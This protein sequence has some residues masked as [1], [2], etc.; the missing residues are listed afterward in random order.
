MAQNDTQPVMA[1]LDRFTGPK[2]RWIMTLSA[3][4]GLG[5][6]VQ[7]V[8]S[9]EDAKAALIEYGKATGFYQDLT[10]WGDYGP[11]GSLYPY[12]E[13]DWTEAERMRDVGNPFDYPSY[14]VNSGPRGGVKVIPA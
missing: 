2:Y 6:D 5:Y 4:G 1:V 13:E 11:T 10:V 12:T 8:T 14:L 7:R 3:P 9:F